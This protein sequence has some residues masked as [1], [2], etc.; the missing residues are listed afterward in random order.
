MVE[1][2][3]HVEEEHKSH[4]S[5]SERQLHVAHQGRFFLVLCLEV[6]GSRE[7]GGVDLVRNWEDRQALCL[8]SRVVKVPVLKRQFLIPLLLLFLLLLNFKIYL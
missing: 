7:D 6:V 4:M 1:W 5:E 2:L 8:D 3:F